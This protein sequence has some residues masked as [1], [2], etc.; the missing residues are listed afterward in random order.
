MND[1][2]FRSLCLLGAK[3]EKLAALAGRSYTSTNDLSAKDQAEWRRVKALADAAA[4]AE[5]ERQ[6]A[7]DAN[8]GL[9]GCMLWDD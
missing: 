1:K 8:A 5:D 6:R 3:M 7:R 2:D 9:S 4:E